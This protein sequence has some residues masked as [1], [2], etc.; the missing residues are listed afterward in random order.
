MRALMIRPVMLS[1]A[2][3]ALLAMLDIAYRAIQPLFFSTPIYL[4]GLGQSP[5]RIG[6][7]LAAFGIINGTFQATYFAKLIEKLGPRIIFLIGLGM[8]MVLFSMF[9]I[10]NG[11]ALDGGV[12]P[13]VWFLV[14]LQLGLSI[15]CDMA[16]GSW[17]SSVYLSFI[18]HSPPSFHTIAGS[19]LPTSRVSPERHIIAT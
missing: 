11:M 8:Y 14:A 13:L 12:T 6:T 4:G 7:T 15:A 2:G 3:Y 1:V 18:A 10:I 5:A 9:P 16:Y 19:F 17:Y